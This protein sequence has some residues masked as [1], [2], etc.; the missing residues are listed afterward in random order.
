MT[1]REPELPEGTDHIINGALETGSGAEASRGSGGRGASRADRGF[2][3]SGDTRNDDGTGGTATGGNGGSTVARAFNEGT[4]ALKRQAGDR[5]RQFADEGKTRVSDA[6]DEAARAVE[7]AA[8]LVDERLGE[9][10]G[11]YARRAADKVSGI[12]TSLREKEVDELYE[13]AR[14][15]VRTSPVLTVGVAA[16]VGFALVRLIRAGMPAEEQENPQPSTAKR[17]RS[18]KKG[19]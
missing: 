13:D 11:T 15:F 16:A 10:Y 5:V 4:A 18:R 17:S 9:Q 14:D 19:A 3:G 1:P 7:E 8:G 2:I 6:L 12:A